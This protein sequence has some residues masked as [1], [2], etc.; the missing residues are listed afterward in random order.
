ME[1][2]VF[3]V[4]SKGKLSGKE[5]LIM[6]NSVILNNR[7]TIKKYRRSL[8]IDK[9]VLGK[10]GGILIILF[11]VYATDTAYFAANIPTKVLLL[12]IGFIVLFLVYVYFNLKRS[13]LSIPF[14][15]FLFLIFF[16]GMVITTM[17]YNS[18]SVRSYLHIILLIFCGFFVTELLSFQVFTRM[19]KTFMLFL[20]I[21]SLIA[22]IV[23]PLIL[24]HSL[25]LPNFTNATGVQFI[26]LGVT[27]IPVISV[28]RNFGVFW[29]PGVFQAYINLA[30]IFELFFNKQFPRS[31]YILIFILT[32][33]ST[34]STTGLICLCLI[35]IAYMIKNKFKYIK[36]FKT[37]AV[38]IVLFMGLLISMQLH[39]DIYFASYNNSVFGKL[40]D[41]GGSF[42]ERINA[43]IADFYVSIHNPLF[44]VG[45]NNN[46]EIARQAGD[47]LG[48]SFKSNTNTIAYWLASYGLFLGL[49]LVLLYIKLCFRI[50]G[51]N[52]LCFYVILVIGAVLLIL[53][54]ENFLNSL[55]FNTLIF[56]ALD[57]NNRE[58]MLQE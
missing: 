5:I 4:E 39:P 33:F 37:I 25:L 40:S 11:T 42:D 12:V 2:P 19:F 32:I 43:T 1:F 17:L 45:I 49:I 3:A 53:A 9:E 27:N 54:S 38:I 20:C 58:L 6:D 16:M 8:T 55:L 50:C 10:I 57:G 15:K 29:E 35:I 21:A 30:L 7:E 52:K 51:E 56:Y 34:L 24:Q 48:R 36:H 31:N 22:F 41:I 14:Y 28:N 44:G 46:I 18:D 23:K 26:N 47:S 13:N